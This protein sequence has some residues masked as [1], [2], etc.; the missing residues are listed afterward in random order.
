VE[1]GKAAAAVLSTVVT[2]LLGL[3]GYRLRR[4]YRRRRHEARDR[5]VRLNLH[6]PIFKCVDKMMLSLDQFFYQINTNLCRI[7]IP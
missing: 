2:G 7:H 4:R 6:F 3:L 1:L 5:Q